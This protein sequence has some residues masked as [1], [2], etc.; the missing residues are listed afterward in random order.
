MDSLRETF[1]D[2]FSDLFWTTGDNWGNPN[3]KA[4]GMVLSYF[5]N[6]I[7]DLRFL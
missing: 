6:K 3:D 5:I 2:Q 7:Y 1:P 4:N